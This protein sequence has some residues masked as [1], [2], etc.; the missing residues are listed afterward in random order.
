[1]KRNDEFFKQ[2]NGELQKAELPMSEQLKNEPIRMATPP[3]VKT[4]R[5][6]PRMRWLAIVASALAACVALCVILP[7]LPKAE[8]GA[9]M[10]I[11]VNP[12]VA[13]LLDGDFKVEKV[14]SENADGDAVLSDGNFLSSLTGATAEQAAKALAERTAQMGFFDLHNTGNDGYNQM[15]VSFSSEVKIA[16]DKLQSVQSAVTEFFKEKGVYVYVNAE[17]ETVR[18]FKAFANRLRERSVAWYETAENKRERALETLFDFAWDILRDGFGWYDLYLEIDAAESETARWPLLEKMYYTYGEDYREYGLEEQLVLGFYGE[19]A[20][21]YADE[22]R[23]YLSMEFS[24]NTLG[25]FAG[26]LTEF[27]AFATIT[28]Y[29]DE[30][31]TAIKMAI[32]VAIDEFFGTAHDFASEMQTLWQE[33]SASLNG[34]YK[35]LFDE[36]REPISDADYQAFL[37]KIQKI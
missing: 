17:S 18:D 33:Y 4:E 8:Q 14:V 24:E 2:L 6:F 35:A 31:M 25:S 32:R 1:M 7:S 37:E 22:L 29:G 26:H 12:S 16:G 21:K 20:G 27:T 19:T 28:G 30:L 5:K 13:V 23:P 34:K 11:D 15:T 36:G 10:Y 3:S 9:C